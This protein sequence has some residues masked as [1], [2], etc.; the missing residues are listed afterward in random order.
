V[1]QAIRAPEAFRHIPNEHIMHPF[2]EAFAKAAQTMQ[3]L[4]AFSLWSPLAR[5]LAWGIAY[6]RPVEP[7][8]VYSPGHDFRDY[9]Q[10]WWKVGDWRPDGELHQLFQNIGRS[11]Y[12]ETLLEYWNVGEEPG[13]NHLTDQETFEES[14]AALPLIRLERRF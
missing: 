1:L 13:E 6:A 2:L 5:G 7:A 12:G 9:R 3:S 4:K 8:T 14:L 11:Q 10:I